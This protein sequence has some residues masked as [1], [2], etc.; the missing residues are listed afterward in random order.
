MGRT[1]R[2]TAGAAVAVLAAAACASSADGELP[3]PGPPIDVTPAA[4]AGVIDAAG[5]E[6][7]TYS[8]SI[9]VDSGSD[10]IEVLHATGEVDGDMVRSEE[11]LAAFIADHEIPDGLAADALVVETVT[12]PEALYV[13]SPLAAAYPP[14]GLAPEA[15]NVLADALADGWVT[16]DLDAIDTGGAG[17]KSQPASCRLIGAG[18]DPRPLLDMARGLSS[19][20]WVDDDAAGSELDGVPV[21]LLT[22]EVP[23]AV[24]ESAGQPGCVTTPELGEPTDLTVP[25]DAWVDR[26]GTIR[27]LRVTRDLSEVAEALVDAGEMSPADAAGAPVLTYTVELSDHG[28]ETIEVAV[29]DEATDVTVP[30]QRL[31][32]RTDQVPTE[33]GSTPGDPAELAPGS[34]GPDGEGDATLPELEEYPTFEELYPGHADGPPEPE[35][36]DPGPV[37]PYTPPETSAPP[38]TGEIERDITDLED[39]IDEIE[40]WEPPEL[41]EPP[42]TPVDPAYT[43]PGG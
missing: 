22:G 16:V 36:I 27:R 31:V 37:E 18:A 9:E 40:D 3:E 28:D 2:M 23:L 20:E 12:G 21:E 5:G 8:L 6:P 15:Q 10:A 43:D 34:S 7:Y 24:V 25:V 26:A 38:D 35:D 30:F 14:S 11:D 4:L 33:P 19:V 39:E 29:P 41:P 32:D 42:S 17:M 13:R 1:H